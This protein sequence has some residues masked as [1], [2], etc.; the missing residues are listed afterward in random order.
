MNKTTKLEVRL[1]P[2]SKELIDEFSKKLKSV[3]G[4]LLEL[5]KTLKEKIKLQT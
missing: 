2:E 1:E 4:L 3:E 5:K